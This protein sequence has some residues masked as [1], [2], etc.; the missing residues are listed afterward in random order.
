MR[1][2]ETW[3]HRVNDSFDSVAFIWHL[4]CGLFFV[5]IEINVCFS[6]IKWPENP[7]NKREVFSFAGK[8]QQGHMFYFYW[9]K[10][11]F[12]LSQY[13]KFVFPQQKHPQDWLGKWAN[14]LQHLAVLIVRVILLSDHIALYTSVLSEQ[15]IFSSK[16][17]WSEKNQG[18]QILIFIEKNL[19]VSGPMWFKPMSFKG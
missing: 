5:K 15:I 19:H 8:C 14:W 7:I 1:L 17:L 18:I 2:H 10:P 3:L 12:K 16:V 4:W 13:F 9:I 6:F 11:E